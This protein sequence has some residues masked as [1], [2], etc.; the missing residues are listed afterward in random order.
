[1]HDAIGLFHEI[2]NREGLTFD[3]KDIILFLNKK[4]LFEEC[5]L[6]GKSLSCCFTKEAR[7]GVK[8]NYSLEIEDEKE[9]G[10][11]KQNRFPMWD[12]KT[13]ADQLEY[14]GPSQIATDDH[15]GHELFKRCVDSQI[16]FIQ[17][18][19]E[20]QSRKSTEG[21]TWSHVITAI[22]QKS[23]KRVFQLVVSQVILQNTTISSAVQE[24]LHVQNCSLS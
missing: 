20:A 18:V 19:F 12:P 4:D 7:W 13:S 24:S 6:K 21:C 11:Y 22:D 3:K 5:V 8:D 15:D 2:R 10:N 14:T 16:L 1:M 17:H 9:S 23:T